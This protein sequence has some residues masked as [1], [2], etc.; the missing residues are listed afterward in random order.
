MRHAAFR[1]GVPGF[2][3]AAGSGAA[4]AGSAVEDAR[5][6]GDTLGAPRAASE[7]AFELDVP[8]A[9]G[10][11][12]TTAVVGFGVG[13]DGLGFGV[14]ADAMSTMTARDPST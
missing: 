5:G 11:G 12:S 3:V 6:S 4:D 9:I 14:H 2:G 10:V 8:P 1:L 13:A 7:G